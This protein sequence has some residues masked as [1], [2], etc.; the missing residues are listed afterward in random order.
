L[1][2]TEILWRLENKEKLWPRDTLLQCL[3]R[4]LLH[5]A[6]KEREKI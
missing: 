6:V 2:E 4:R 1:F 3:G 5:E